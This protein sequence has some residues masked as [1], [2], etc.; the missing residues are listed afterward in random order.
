V[1]RGAGHLIPLAGQVSMD[2]YALY[3]PTQPREPAGGPDGGQWSSDG[4]GSWTPEDSVKL[5][6]YTRTG[7]TY[8][9]VNEGLRAGKDMSGHPTVAALEKAFK[10]RGDA[11]P[12]QVYRGMAGWELEELG[13]EVGKTFTDHGY[14]STATDQQT[15]K[16]FAMAGET[17]MEGEAVGI[18]F[19]IN[20]GGLRSLDMNP[21]SRYGENERLLPKGLTFKVT[22]VKPGEPG[23]RLAVVTMS[24]HD[25]Q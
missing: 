24:I 7:G 16:K 18:V 25:G 19:K 22:S 20:T 23:R 12:K 14:V 21:F 4:G 17:K 10:E 5:Q 11:A 9:E 8:R 2:F 3:D 13:L 6:D 15:A 1:Q